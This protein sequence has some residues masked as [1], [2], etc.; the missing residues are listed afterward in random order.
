ISEGTIISFFAA[1]I[2]HEVCVH[3]VFFANNQRF[4]TCIVE[5][6]GSY[7]SVYEHLKT[8]DKEVKEAAAKVEEAAAKVEEAAAKV[9]EAAAKVAAS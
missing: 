7:E 5:V 3:P 4:D 1:R 9:E 6:F 8:K 2:D